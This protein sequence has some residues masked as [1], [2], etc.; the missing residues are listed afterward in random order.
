MQDRLNRVL[1][2]SGDEKSYARSQLL[3]DIA[4]S[5]QCL[6]VC[7]QATKQVDGLKIHNIG[8]LIAE[9]DTDQVVIPTL[10]DLFN[11]ERV[12]AKSGSAQL[13]G[14]MTD[15]SLKQLSSKR[16][17]GRFGARASDIEHAERK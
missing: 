2:C 5:K 17:N 13:V 7:D 9:N 10:A 3:V 11:V 4:V 14:S 8:P 15:D 16:Y 1:S 6:S 12:E